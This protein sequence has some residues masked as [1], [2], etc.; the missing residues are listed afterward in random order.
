MLSVSFRGKLQ[1]LYNCFL[2]HALGLTNNASRGELT[3]RKNVS[4][5]CAV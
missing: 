5:D 4:E 1:T 3:R 2:L